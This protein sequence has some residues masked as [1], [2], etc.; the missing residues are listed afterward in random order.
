MKIIWYSDSTNIRRYG[1]LIMAA[2]GK[3]YISLG[4]HIPYG[5]H[6]D[7]PYFNSAFETVIFHSMYSYLSILQ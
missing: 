3:C 1:A 5:C 2:K 6:S 7:H 4:E